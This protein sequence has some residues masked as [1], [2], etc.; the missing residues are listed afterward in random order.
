MPALLLAGPAVA[1]HGWRWTDE[2]KFELTGVITEANLGNPHGVLT[3]DAEG[4]TWEA[5]VGQPWRND[6]AGLTD[7]MLAPG[8]EIKIIGKRS[9]NAEERLVKAEAVEIDGE[10]YVLYPDRM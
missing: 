1:H 6:N 2:G 8:T 5:E 7:E 4:E 3:I 10:M 9:A